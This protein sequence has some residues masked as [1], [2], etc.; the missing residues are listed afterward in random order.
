MFAK[1]SFLIASVPFVFEAL[2]DNL[3]SGSRLHKK[4]SE[5]ASNGEEILD[6]SGP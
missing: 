4:I 3:K 5:N 1:C 6:P 2:H